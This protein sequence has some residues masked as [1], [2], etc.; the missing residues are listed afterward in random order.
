VS[1][2]LDVRVLGGS[3]FSKPERFQLISFFVLKTNSYPVE[4]TAL[5]LNTKKKRDRATSDKST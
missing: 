5:E 2:A 1:T 4:L 3:G